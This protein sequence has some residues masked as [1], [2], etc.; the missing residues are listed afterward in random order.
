MSWS[1]YFIAKSPAVAQEEI[2]KLQEPTVEKP[3]GTPA[4]AKKLI[5]DTLA[6]A[7][8]VTEGVGVKVEASGH[9]PDG[10]AKVRVEALTIVG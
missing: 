3:W 4:A 5:L 7:G 8:I 9:S 1:V 10:Q 2:E 6:L